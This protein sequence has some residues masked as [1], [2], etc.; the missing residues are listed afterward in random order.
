[1]SDSTIPDILDLLSH[2]SGGRLRDAASLGRFLAAAEP[3]AKSAEIGELAFQGRYLTRLFDTMKKQ[4]AQ[5][6]HFAGLE[7]E[8]TRALNHFQELIRVFG[9]GGPAE[10]TQFCETHYLAVSESALKHLLALAYDFA[11]LKEWEVTLATDGE[12]TEA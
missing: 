10:F 4:T 6:E 1:M 3:G 9:A 11:W 5:S 12:E 2:F 7:A 8:F